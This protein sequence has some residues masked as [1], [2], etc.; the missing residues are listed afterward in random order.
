MSALASRLSFAAAIAFVSSSVA[1]SRSS[2][3]LCSRASRSFSAISSRSVVRS[4]SAF[5]ISAGDASTAFLHRFSGRSS[6]PGLVFSRASSS[7]LV[8]SASAASRSTFSFSS[9]AASLRSASRFLRPSVVMMSTVLP[10]PTF[11]EC[12]SNVFASAAAIASTTA[13]TPGSAVASDGR[14]SR[15]CSNS[16]L[17]ASLA[18]T[19]VASQ[20][21]I[22]LTD[23]LPSCSVRYTFRLVC[24]FSSTRSLSSG[25]LW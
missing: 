4:A 13:S 5:S 21:A 18:P 25:V 2:F 9:R 14:Y 6:R 8:S 10:K 1:A 3:S 16:S 24:V 23:A 20:P 17:L 15:A 22:L 7:A 11:F 19:L 12:S